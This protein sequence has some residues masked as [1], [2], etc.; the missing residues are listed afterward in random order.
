MSTWVRHFE[1]PASAFDPSQL[2]QSFDVGMEDMGSSFCPQVEPSISRW[3]DLLPLPFVNQKGVSHC[4]AFQSVGAKRRSVRRSS[5]AEIVNGIVTTL[6]EMAGFAHPSN[7]KP[8]KAQKLAH[9]QLFC[10]VA[11]MPRCA[12]RVQMR[13]AVHELLHTGLSPYATEDEARSTVRSYS[14]GLVSLPESGA[15]VFQASELLDEAGRDFLLDPQTHLFVEHFDAKSKVKPYMDEVLRF[16]DHA[17]HDFIGDLWERGMLTFGHSCRASITPFFVVKKSGKLRL[18]LDCR[19]AN[20]HFKPP[21]DIAMAA[22]YSFGQLVVEHDQ[23]VFVAQPDIKDYFYSI[24]LPD[25]LHPFF[26]LPPIRSDLLSGRIPELCGRDPSLVIFPQMKVVPM[27]WSWAMFFAQRIHQ[28]QV[29]IGAGIPH[30]R[31]LADGRPAPVLKDE[32]GVIVPFADN[33]NV[34]G[35]NKDEVQRVKDQAVAQLRKVGF[36]VHE[37]EDASL[38][39]KALGFIINGSK[40][41]IFPVPEKRDKVIQCLIWLSR[42][43]RVSGRVVE[44]IIGHCVHFFT[45]HREMLS[46]FRSVYDFKTAHYNKQ[47][48]LWRSAADECRWAANLLWICE[49]DMGKQW[50]GE[51]TVSDACLSGTATCSMEI[52][53][54]DAAEIGSTRE[55]WRYKSRSSCV[56]AREIVRQLDPF[57]DIETVSA[58]LPRLDP[59][60]LNL[61]FQ[62]VPQE[63]AQ[64]DHWEVQFSSRMFHKEPITVI[65]GRATV[66]SIRHKTRSCKHFNKRHLHFGDNLGM[67]LAFDRGRAKSFSLLLCCRRACAFSLADGC[68]FHHRWLPSEWNKDDGPSRKWE[69]EAVQAPPSKRGCQ[70]TISEI[71]Y[72]TD[73]AR[74][75][76]AVG[77]VKRWASHPCSKGSGGQ[78]DQAQGA[79]VLQSNADD[80]EGK[81]QRGKTK[82]SSPGDQ[83]KSKCPTLCRSDSFRDAGSF[84]THGSRLSSEGFGVS[85]LLQF[86][87][88]ENQ[89]KLSSRPC[90]D[91]FSQPKLRR[92]AGHFRG[93]KGICSSTRS[94]S[95]CRSSRSKPQPEVFEGLEEP[96]SRSK[97][98]TTGLALHQSPCFD[99][100]ATG[101]GQMCSL[102][103]HHVHNLHSSMR[104]SEAVEEGC[105][106]VNGLGGQLG[107]QREHVRGGSTVK[108][109]ASRRGYAARQQDAGLPRPSPGRSG[110]G[111]SFYNL[112]RNAIPS[113]P[114][115]MACNAGPSGLAHGDSRSVPAPSLRGILGSTQKGAFSSGNQ[116]A[117]KVEFGCKPEAIRESCQGC[118]T[119]R[120]TAGQHQKE[121]R[122]IS[123]V[124]ERDGYRIYVPTHPNMLRPVLELFAGSAAFSKAMCKLGFTVH[125]Y[126][127]QWGRG[128]DIL[129]PIVF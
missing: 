75:F 48:R 94:F 32:S 40:R 128:G 16:D 91:C 102:H 116:T 86:T 108:S 4:G 115:N 51:V 88:V 44:R 38:E 77:K 34:I 12:H 99:H 52:H 55:L 28:H 114:Q 106:Q 2:D 39:A 123:S 68:Q 117:R 7:E 64:S 111:S 95:S 79:S 56:K 71:I 8:S 53:A 84:T 9:Q 41:K 58:E 20:E 119:L 61:D 112:V 125:A 113:A 122:F 49:S 36:R 93:A 37:E 15:S 62:N 121:S 89:H 100:D 21:P 120:E 82:E 1:D 78:G 60:Q 66:Q 90:V 27:G 72:P 97:S 126:D 47:V 127:I 11:R 43:P 33:L 19:Q 13:E 26:S 83:R 107:S 74:Q 50:S 92:G 65:E 46:I 31:V 6:N 17:Y 23:E 98:N 45:L 67:V 124:I 42:R 54:K 29:M 96:R 103:S 76:E 25:Y 70:R 101:R 5:N 3:R 118:P 57:K 104:S 69:R 22:G 14:K 18:V 10:Q 35:T 30:H 59:F 24:G 129:D 63:L 87:G 105:S 80:S 73:S 81:E 109:G 110:A 85:K